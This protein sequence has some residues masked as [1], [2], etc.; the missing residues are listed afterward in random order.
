MAGFTATARAGGQLSRK[1]QSYGL[2]IE[3]Y[4]FAWCTSEPKTHSCQLQKE[5]EMPS[6]LMEVEFSSDNILQQIMLHEQRFS[7]QLFGAFTCSIRSCAEHFVTPV[8][9]RVPILFHIYMQA[10]FALKSWWVYIW[11]LQTFSLPIEV[12]HSAVNVSQVCCVI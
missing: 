9:Y 7:G 8:N 2:V 10:V 6:F 1:P 5:G 11:I 3:I 4:G 12:G